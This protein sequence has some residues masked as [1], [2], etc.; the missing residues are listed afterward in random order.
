MLTRMEILILSGALIGVCI[1]VAFTQS[2][3]L[4]P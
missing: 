3:S 2:N 4:H 1:M